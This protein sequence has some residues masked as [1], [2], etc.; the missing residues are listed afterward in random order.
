MS[1]FTYQLTADSKATTMQDMFDFVNGVCA[2]GLHTGALEGSFRKRGNPIRRCNGCNKVY[3]NDY[4]TL[5]RSGGTDLVGEWENLNATDIC[6]YLHAH[7][8]DVEYYHRT[9]KRDDR[10]IQPY[11]AYL[12]YDRKLTPAEL[13][14]KKI[15]GEQAEL[16]AQMAAIVAMPDLHS[17]RL[18]RDWREPRI[19]RSH[20][21]QITRL[22]SSSFVF[23]SVCIQDFN[24]LYRLGSYVHLSHP[25]YL[26]WDFSA[27]ICKRYL[28]PRKEDP[29]VA[30]RSPPSPQKT[31]PKPLICGETVEDGYPTLGAKDSP[32]EVGSP[33]H[34]SSSPKKRTWAQRPL[35]CGE[36]GYPTLGATSS[37]PEVSSHSPSSSSP[38]VRTWA[39]RCRAP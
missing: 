28:D 19:G 31:K 10:R 4:E 37:R 29:P 35:I 3:L 23:K 34:A 15:I 16:D 17:I 11:M 2:Y 14:V 18:V 25:C 32:S 22:V 12:R 9:G 13:D 8:S 24:R 26:H 21:V 33:S 5:N 20:D 39:Q 38:K 6:P 7:E 1:S 36:T 30:R 27:D